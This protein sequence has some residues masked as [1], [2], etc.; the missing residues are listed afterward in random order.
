VVV[1][2]N[3][4]NRGVARTTLQAKI[5]LFLNRLTAAGV[6]IVQGQK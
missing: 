5:Q 6:K 2:W 4:Q 3:H 1:F